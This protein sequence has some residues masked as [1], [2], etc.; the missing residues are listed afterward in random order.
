MA[1]VATQPRKMTAE[2]FAQGY[3]GKRAELID[4]EVHEYMPTNPRHAKVVSRTTIYLGRYA[5]ENGLGDVL[6]GEPGYIIRS[7]E[8]ES[9]RAPDVAFIRKERIPEEGWGEGFCTVI[10]DLVVEVISP[11]D[12]YPQLRQKIDQWLSAG[13]Q[14]VWVIDPE[15]RV[16]EIWR[17][18]G[19]VKELKEND[20]LTGAPV[21][22]EFQVA[23]KELF[24]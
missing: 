3:M 5:Y 2:E 9:V 7:G 23:V 13:V 14:V 8:S 11:S 1:T 15:R 19:T 21:L 18:D 17:P 10:P 4:G 6:T 12:S 22:P 16:V 20:T 24:G